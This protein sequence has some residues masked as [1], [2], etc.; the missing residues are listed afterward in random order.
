MGCRV[1]KSGGASIKDFCKR[2]PR[3]TRLLNSVGGSWSVM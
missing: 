3:V 1:G 2:T